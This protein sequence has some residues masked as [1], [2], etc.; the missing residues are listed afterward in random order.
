[1]KFW[2]GNLLGSD[3]LKNLTDLFLDYLTT[4]FRLNMLCIVERD[5]KMVMSGQQLRIWNGAFSVCFVLRNRL[6]K[7]TKHQRLAN[8][9]RYR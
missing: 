1:M 5:W 8:L 9:K 3:H 7:T 2:L 6:R 4:L